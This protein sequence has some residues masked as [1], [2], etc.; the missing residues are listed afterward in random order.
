M[1]PLRLALFAGTSFF[2]GADS[3]AACIPKE[4]QLS[5]DAGQIY[6]RSAVLPELTLSVAAATLG[7]CIRACP[8]GSGCLV[9]FDASKAPATCYYAALPWDPEGKAAGHACMVQMHQ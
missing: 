2:K 8:Q 7:D 1:L 3:I 9:Q 5:P 6:F 4:S